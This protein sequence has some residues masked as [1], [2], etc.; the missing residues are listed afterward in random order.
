[1]MMGARETAFWWGVTAANRCHGVDAQLAV[2]F[3]F[4]GAVAN[5]ADTLLAQS[6]VQGWRRPGEIVRWVRREPR[7]FAELFWYSMPAR[8]ASSVFVPVAVLNVF[9]K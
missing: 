7:V 3:V 5:V 8:V 1:M 9:Q 4:G 6:V 2:Q